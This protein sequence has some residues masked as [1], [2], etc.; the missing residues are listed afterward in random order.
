PFNPLVRP[1]RLAALAPQDEETWHCPSPLPIPGRATCLARPSDPREKRGE[2]APTLMPPSPCL[3]GEGK[4]E[5][6]R[7]PRPTRM[8]GRRAPPSWG[9]PLSL[10]KGS[11]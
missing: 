5:G 1:S 11:L 2:G 8:R 9:A 10:S 3:R 6:Q 7:R 4:G